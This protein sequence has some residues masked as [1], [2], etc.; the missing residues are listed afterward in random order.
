MGGGDL[1][2]G[3]DLQNRLP[4]PHSSVAQLPEVGFQ[5]V[6]VENA[7]EFHDLARGLIFNPIKI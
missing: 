7:R 6:R 4:P 3:A 5:K 1:S 2:A